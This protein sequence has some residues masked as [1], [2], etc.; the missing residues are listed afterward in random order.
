MCP[1]CRKWIARLESTGLSK[2]E[3]RTHYLACHDPD[4]DTRCTCREEVANTA[5]LML[6]RGHKHVLWESVPFDFAASF[7]KLTKSYIE[8][9]QEQFNDLVRD[10]PSRRSVGVS[11]RKGPVLEVG[12]LGVTLVYLRKRPRISKDTR[13]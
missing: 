3:A 13:N 8:W 10:L 7:E 9:N 6:S 1:E 11:L 5:K 4:M 2:R 12:R